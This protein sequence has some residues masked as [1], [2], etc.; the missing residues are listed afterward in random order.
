MVNYSDTLDQTLLLGRSY[1]F[2]KDHALRVSRLAL[3]LFDQLQPLHDMGNTE[4]IWLRTGALLH[5][6]GKR[7]NPKDHHKVARDIIVD[8]SDLP[9]RRPQR[10]LIGLVARY[11][12]GAL[13]NKRHAYFR[14]LE[15]EAK[16]YVTKLA[17]LLRLAD[18]LDKGRAG[19]VEDVRCTLERATVRL[20]LFGRGAPTADKIRR[21]AGLLERVFAR[22]V[23]I[24]SERTRER[25][26]FSLASTD[27]TPYSQTV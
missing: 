23:V 14:D 22:S 18:G 5:D 9:F 4:R 25:L 19:L 10:I 2:E 11:H 21:K 26:G 6:V 1:R 27:E 8:A 3:R 17:A 15:P 12:R 13:P 20:T 7:I 24:N 16:R